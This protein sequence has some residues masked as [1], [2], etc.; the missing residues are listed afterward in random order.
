MIELRD[1]WV[2]WHKPVFSI[3]VRPAL[4]SRFPQPLRRPRATHDITVITK[5][6]YSPLDDETTI[7]TELFGLNN[8][9]KIK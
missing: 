6:I 1:C 8:Q 2:V 4:P 5:V 3:T 7:S 9:R